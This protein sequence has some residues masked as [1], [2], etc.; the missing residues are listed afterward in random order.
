LLRDGLRIRSLAPGVVPSRRRTWLEDDWS[1]DATKRLLDTAL[2]A[3]R[4]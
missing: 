2:L 1:L 4:H 3:Q